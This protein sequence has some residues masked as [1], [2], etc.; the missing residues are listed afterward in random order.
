[1]EDA[2]KVRRHLR[3]V[4]AEVDE[5]GEGTVGK[6]ILQVVGVYARAVRHHQHTV[7]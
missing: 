6:G 3:C 1:M 7:R 4:R 2:A 5:L